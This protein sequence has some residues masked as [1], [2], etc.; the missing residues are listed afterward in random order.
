MNTVALR[1]QRYKTSINFLCFL[2]RNN[3][4]A[5]IHTAF[6]PPFA[7]NT[8]ANNRDFP[9]KEMIIHNDKRNH[10]FC[11]KQ[12]PKSYSYEKNNYIYRYPNEHVNAK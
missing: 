11:A 8:N 5:T 9:M 12:T 2:G 6:T 7:S 10:Y 4:S 3:P 1:W